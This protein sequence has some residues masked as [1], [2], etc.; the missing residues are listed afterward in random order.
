MKNKILYIIISLLCI[1]SCGDINYYSYIRGAI[2][3]YYYMYQDGPPDQV[4]VSFINIHSPVIGKIGYD[5]YIFPDSTIKEY[6]G[7][8]SLFIC[9]QDVLQYEYSYGGF[10]YDCNYKLYNMSYNSIL[11]DYLEGVI[12]VVDTVYNMPI[13][14]FTIEP[15]KF[16]LSLQR[17]GIDTCDMDDVFI[18]A[19]PKKYIPTV[20]VCFSKEKTAILEDYN[21]ISYNR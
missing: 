4:Y 11:Y 5:Y 13:Y 17:Q 2:Y 14:K 20:C 21:P 6:R 19:F 1:S 15:E 3:T 7:I 10:Q 8:D 18:Y 9:R 12:Q 16:I